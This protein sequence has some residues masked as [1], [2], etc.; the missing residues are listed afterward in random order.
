MLFAVVLHQPFQHDG[1]GGHVDSQS[2]CL[3]G[4]DGLHQARGEEFLDGVAEHR[5]QS[6]VVGGQAA[7][8][9]F[10]PFVIAQHYEVALGQLRAAPVDHLGDAA[11]FGVVGE[12]QR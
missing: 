3:G 5:K 6:G 4:E 9:T 12:P 10:A 2:Q 1:A 11:A 7:Q 8:Q